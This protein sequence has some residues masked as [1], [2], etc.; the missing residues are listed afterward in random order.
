M[1]A[2]MAATVRTSSEA[3]RA[4]APYAG[5]PVT[6]SLKRSGTGVPVGEGRSCTPGRSSGV[7]A[8]GDVAPVKRLVLLG[9]P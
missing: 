5:V 8:V 9:V 6:G 4:A 1:G 3:S 2:H 7:E